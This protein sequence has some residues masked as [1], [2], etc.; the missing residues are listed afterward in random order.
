MVLRQKECRQKY[1][2]RTYVILDVLAPYG[3]HGA[4]GAHVA[5]TLDAG[6]EKLD[7]II[8]YGSAG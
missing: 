7:A 1:R 6:K 2:D 5:E 3:A 8:Q 4:H